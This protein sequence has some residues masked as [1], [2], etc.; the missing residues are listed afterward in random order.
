MS[1]DRKIAHFVTHRR[2][3][4]YIWIALAIALCV[5]LCVFRMRLDSEVLNLLPGSFDSVKA[6]KVFNNDFSQNLELTFAVYDPDHSTDM[7]GFTEHFATMLKKE[8]WVKRVVYQVPMESDEGMNEITT[9]ALPLL[10]N[11]QP[12]DFDESLAMLQP[13]K[14]REHIHE[15]KSRIEAGSF[16]YEWEYKLDPLGPIINA[17]KPL[18]KMAATDQ[19][20]SFTSRDGELHMVFVSTDQSGPGT[21][22]CREMMK[23]VK[24]FEN[25]VYAS[26]QGKAPELLLTGRTPYVAELS[27]GMEIDIIIT[28]LGSVVLVSGIF[29]IGFQRVRPLVAIMHV[30]LLCCI[31]AVTAGGVIFHALNGIAIGFC[32]ILVGLGVDFGMLLYGSYQTQRNE[33]RDHEAAIAGAIRQIGKG[34]LFGAAT[35]AAGFLTHTM[36][37]CEGFVQLGVLIAIGIVLAALL[38]LTVFFVF[39]GSKHVPHRH[40]WL[41]DVMLKFVGAVFRSPRSFVCVSGAV[42]LAASIFTF[43]PFKQIVFH[44]DPKSLQPQDS[45]AW[46][47]LRIIT[48]KMTIDGIEPVMV[49]VDGRDSDEFHDRWAKLQDHWIKEFEAGHLKNVSSPAPL[50]VS[51]SLQQQNV[52]KLSGIDFEATR[53]NLKKIME[54]EGFTADSYK[55]SLAL[56]DSMEAVSKGNVRLLDWGV[57]VPKN[58]VWRFLL[59]KF[60]GTT[61]NLAVAYITPNTRITTV[62][63]KEALEKTLNTEGVP[64]RITG[65][66]YTLANLIPW[67]HSKLLELSVAII[68]FNVILLIFLYRRLFPLLV[69]MVSLFLSIGAMVATLKILGIALNLFNVLAF[70]LVLGVGVDYG[71]Y[72]LLAMRNNDN[73]HR[74]L[75]TILKP[76]FLSGLCTTCGFGSL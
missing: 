37:G 54:E 26:W 48:S 57:T 56:L 47:A 29:Y 42:L 7:E 1:F 8:P 67:S 69:L 34:V 50:V 59:D 19:S 70:P 5:V 68:A 25:R 3:F 51:K 17:L 43:L 55:N 32:S 21:N 66:S 16:R 39:L 12:K 10:F 24:D 44:A 41:F 20:Q 58:S 23:K 13:D 63:D 53:N 35:T 74:A 31:F 36:S 52:A 49:L 64:I 18:G 72:V 40:D 75:T 46:R 65:W 22:E 9:V 45:T 11:L 38:M 15:M 30:L 71:I 4:I 14:M 33:G 62:E 6:L 61:P 28:L 76:V 73:E 60:F 27:R 2:K